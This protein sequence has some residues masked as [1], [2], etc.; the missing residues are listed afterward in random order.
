M[1]LSSAGLDLICSFEGYHKALPDGR[2]IAY[3][4]PAGVLTLGWGCTEGVREGM[5]WTREEAQ[6]A[7]RRELAK[8]EAGVIRLTTV[9][10]NQNQFDALVS[11]TYN[12]GL[13]A[14]EGSTLRRKLNAGDYRS[15]ASAFKL[16]NKG[17]GRVL[18]G[19]VNRRAREATLF[20]TPMDEPDEPDMPQA[21]QP[22]AEPVGKPT[23][24]VAAASSGA[25][26]PAV[27]A[28][29][30]DNAANASSWQAAGDQIL[31]LAKWAVA[32]PLAL[33]VVAATAALLFLPKLIGGKA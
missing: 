1:K 2:C 15:A 27:P 8:F 10:L 6:V 9:P 24:A 17:G 32:S 23:V 29:L 3:R 30:T 22:S 16:W 31:G 4:C 21:V 14:F 28:L 11:F 13:G 19:L 33:A 26:I 5:I 20:L 12:V 25:V 7:L 18:P